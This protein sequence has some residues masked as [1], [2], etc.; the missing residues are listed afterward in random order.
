[1]ILFIDT[2]S[3][4]CFLWIFDEKK[5]KIDEIKYDIRWNESTTLINSIDSLI[6]KNKK[7]YKDIENIIIVN[8][9]GSFTW[10]RTSVLVANTINFIIWKNIST[11]DYF[12]IIE[13]N[14]DYS[15]PILK[16]SSKR[17][18]FIKKQRNDKIETLDN[19]NVLSYIKDN[20]IENIYWDSNNIADFIKVQTNIDYKKVLDK[21]DL[22]NE[23]LAQAFY[24]KKPNIS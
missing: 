4:P 13:L 18:I 2:I 9:P 23:K 8:W 11:I 22:K 10:I 15:Y 3:N 20:K 6:K 12:S 19:E 24:L 21:I 17:D 16:D 14:S 1:M 7:T 5:E